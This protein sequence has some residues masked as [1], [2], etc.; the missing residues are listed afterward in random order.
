MQHRLIGIVSE[1]H[2]GEAHIAAQQRVA[3]V[4]RGNRL[5]LGLDGHFARGS[6]QFL[7][8]LERPRA[9]VAF[10]ALPRPVA[11][12]VVDL[13]HGTA[14]L[15]ELDVDER[16]GAVV[17]LH[18]LVH[19]LEDS[20]GA[21]ER[22]HHHGQLLGDLADRVDERT[23]EGEQR[24]EGAE[25]ERLDA[26]QAEIVDAG[27]RNGCADD[28]EQDVEQVSH[29]ADHRHGDVAPGVRFGGR[30]EQ[31]LVLLVEGLLRGVLVVED[32]DD[33][34]AV[35]G[36]LHE[37]VHVADPHLLLDEVA[38]GTA[39]DL[40]HDEVEQH[41]EHDHERGE[42]NREPQHG[43]QRRQR[44]D[45]R[46]EHLRERLRDRLTQRIGVVGVVAHDVAVFMAVEVA[47]RQL[48]L[49]GE[50]V[51]ADLLERA[52]FD[53]DDQPLPGPGRHD[54]GQVQAAHKRDGAQQ[55]RPVGICLP[56]HRQD[57]RVDEGLEEQRGS[58]LRGGADQDADHDGDDAPLV[59]EDVAEDAL[60]GAR[61][62]FAHAGF[63]VLEAL[64]VAH[65]VSPSLVSVS[66][67]APAGSAATSSSGRA[68]FL[69]W[70]S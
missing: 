64:V 53:G 11:G 66:D 61:F 6:V 19:Q 24:D 7:G 3:A 54:T 57:V 50:H 28:G 12:L 9:V 43:Q 62:G 38:A 27:Q 35:D 36:L 45:D 30:L 39:H 13:P 59:L 4:R 52:L 17:G 29:V 40:A 26:G 69:V 48:L 63:A 47:D 44:G 10:L 60:D 22:H 34:L 16:D 49:V 15:A 8:G 68:W 65:R 70:D 25:G 5:L 42:R 32:L 23:G 2:V 18:G 51:V 41:G 58:G 31:L 20:G 33:L 46:G 14:A 67:C 21:G 55:R 1:G 37:G 56:H